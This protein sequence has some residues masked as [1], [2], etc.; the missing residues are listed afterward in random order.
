MGAAMNPDA[1]YVVDFD[2]TII[3]LEPH[4]VIMSVPVTNLR[5]PATNIIYPTR[6]GMI[7]TILLK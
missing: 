1:A 4:G 2:G 6:N 5:K 3:V 7:F